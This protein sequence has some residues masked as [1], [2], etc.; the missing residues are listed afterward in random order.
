MC[1]NRN[2]PHPGTF[3][4]LGGTKQRGLLDQNPM[5]T[6]GFSL[7]GNHFKAS[8]ASITATAPETDSRFSNAKRA[9]VLISLLTCGG[10]K[11][12][13][14]LDPLQHH[15]A[16]NEDGPKLLASTNVARSNFPRARQATTESPPSLTNHRHRP[17]GR[18]MHVR[19][20]LNPHHRSSMMQKGMHRVHPHNVIN[21]TPN[22]NE[23]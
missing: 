1:E 20:I 14:L 15:K 3:D 9:L 2:P 12:M 7:G 6:H 5:T 8:A 22:G 23:I 18:E 11:T 10:D 19:C 21:Q 4:P 17:L 16:P 13:S